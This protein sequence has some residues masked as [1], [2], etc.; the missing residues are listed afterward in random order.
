MGS[1][2]FA[3]VAILIA[4]SILYIRHS[5]KLP[6]SQHPPRPAASITPTTVSPTGEA[7]SYFLSLPAELRLQIYSLLLPSS[8]PYIIPLSAA[9]LPPESSTWA[10]LPSK[11]TS[12]FHSSPP[13]QRHQGY[14]TQ[15]ARRPPALVLAA[16]NQQ[17]RHEILP[18]FYSLN[19]F[20]ITIF[21]PVDLDAV[22]DWLEITDETLSLDAIV[23]LRVIVAGR[24]SVDVLP[25]SLSSSDQTSPTSPISGVSQS[26][27]PDSSST[28][29]ISNRKEVYS[30][31]LTKKIQR[32]RLRY[33]GRRILVSNV[34]L[35]GPMK[36]LLRLEGAEDRVENT[37]Q[38]FSSG[39][40][41]GLVARILRD[42]LRTENMGKRL[43]NRL[44]ALCALD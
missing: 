21:T 40:R 34:P 12:L 2:V 7:N 24:V 43:R 28:E 39:S 27:V 32:R 36:S 20:I 18:I 14:Q 11:I 31:Q 35:T 16:T 44:D 22:V 29:R 26:D 30:P 4:T 9:S 3:T 10:I 33:G 25:I 37:L 42:L 5:S 13:Y 38:R 41:K 17:L 19:S 15:S 6:V 8:S 1:A 23:D